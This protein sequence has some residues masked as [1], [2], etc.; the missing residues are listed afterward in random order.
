[1]SFHTLLIGNPADCQRICEEYRSGLQDGGHQCIGFL[2][3]DPNLSASDDLSLP[4]LGHW[5]EMERIVHLR[6]IR[7]V[8]L[9]PDKKSAEWIEPTIDRLMNL[10]VEIRIVPDMLDILSG[11]VKTSNVLG[12][13]LVE[14]YRADMPIWQRNVKRLMDI[15]VAILSGILLSPVILW[16]AWR[17][18][19]SSPGP[20]LYK[21]ERIGRKG[22]VF[23]L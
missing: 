5:D 2:S 14:V 23:T 11:S 13:P 12:T 9:A 15:M 21:Q 19:K 3:M 4:M 7:L 8:I 17:V 20:I 18:R 16:I 1:M 22:S 6:Q 10:E